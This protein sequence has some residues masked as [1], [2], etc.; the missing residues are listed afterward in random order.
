[1]AT[2]VMEELGVM[3]I[4][5]VLEAVTDM[6]SVPVPERELDLVPEPEREPDLVTV[7]E[8]VIEAEG[9][10]EGVLDTVS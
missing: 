7:A 4:D 2:G 5:P 8:G 9:V 1:M 3:L 6:V 10:T